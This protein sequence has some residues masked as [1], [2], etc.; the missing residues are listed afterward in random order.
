MGGYSG[1]RATVVLDLLTSQKDTITRIFGDITTKTLD[2]LE[3]DIGGI[4]V[5]VKSTHYGQ[6]AKYGHLAV[7]LGKTR[8]CNIIN[9]P[10]FLYNI[11]VNQGA[12][13]PA[14]IGNAATAANRA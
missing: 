12:Y 10:N 14:V 8:M 6:G 4:L 7:I 1:N 11:P 5:S 3:E 2:I 9:D 13:D